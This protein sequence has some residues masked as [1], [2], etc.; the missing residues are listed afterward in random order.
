ML[1]LGSGGGLDVIVSARRTGPTG[2]VYGL[3]AS[4]DMLA[5]ART[6]AEQAG[7]GNA[8]FLYGHIEDIPL[9]DGH[10]DVVISNCVI[11]L[12]ADKSRVLAEAFRVLAP[13]GRLGVADVIAEEELDPGQLAEAEYWVGCGGH[14]HPAAIPGPASGKLGSAASPS[15]ARTRLGPAWHSAI[16]QAAKLA[17][18]HA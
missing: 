11:N 3:D 18:W 8:E 15:P 5:L 6:N 10:V 14:A 2:K 1:D 7:V 9:P 17:T 13:G 16:I 12:A 4:A